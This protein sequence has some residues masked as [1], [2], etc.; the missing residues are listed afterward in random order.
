MRRFRSRPGRAVLAL[1][2]VAYV[3]GAVL[4]LGGFG[5]RTSAANAEY[6]YQGK[7]TICH[8]TGSQKNPQVTITISANALDAHLAHGDTIGP[9]P[10]GG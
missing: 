2:L 8:H 1:A 6:E 5:F 4:V 10:D 7:V 3:V 9:C